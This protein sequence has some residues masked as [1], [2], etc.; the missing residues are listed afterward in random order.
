[1]EYYPAVT[2][3]PQN[4]SASPSSQNPGGPSSSQN[5]DN[6]S[7]ADEQKLTNTRYQVDKKDVKGKGKEK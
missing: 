3:Y 6:S 4:T 7:R 1:M 5:Y 2:S